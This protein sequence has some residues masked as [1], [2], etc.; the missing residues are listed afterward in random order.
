MEALE[1]RKAEL[2]K[3]ISLLGVKIEEK[4]R[5]IID[6]DILKKHLIEFREVFDGLKP[7]EKERLVRLLI[8]ELT[9]YDDKIKISLWDL[10]ETDLSLEAVISKWQFAE[11]QVMLP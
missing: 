6:G 1:N 3:E 9:Y 7:D 8:R 10:P 2:A 4:K 5:Y 11:R